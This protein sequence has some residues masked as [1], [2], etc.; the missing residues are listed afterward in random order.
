MHLISF[1]DRLNHPNASMIEKLKRNIYIDWLKKNKLPKNSLA[2]SVSVGDGI[3]DYLAFK[4]KKN[5][6][7]IIA[8]DIVP[9]PVDPNCIK[10]LKSLGSWEYKKIQAEKPLPFPKDSF[11][12]IFHQD[13]IEHVKKPYMFL[14]QQYKVLKKGGILI[15]GTPNLF[16]PA[17]IL[18]L[19]IGK[20]KFPNK[21]G[22]NIEIGDYVHIQEFY[23]QQ[24]KIL[25]Q[26]IGFQNIEILHIYF[27]FF[28]LNIIINKLPKN[29]IGKSMCHFLMFKCNK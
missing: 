14:S 9:N 5:I 19:L 15:C 23:E 2:L 27:G 28:P 6:K 21:I 12:L 22:H 16:R 10:I 17:N 11:D 1:L 18:K 20:L 4:N 26:E 3:W 25:F 24:L 7:K 13:V 29:I 8:T